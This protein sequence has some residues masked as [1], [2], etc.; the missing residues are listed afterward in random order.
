[1]PVWYFKVSLLH[2][3]QLLANIAGQLFYDY[4]IFPYCAQPNTTVRTANIVVVFQTS[5]L[6]A[7]IFNWQPI[8]Y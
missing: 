4:I 5:V 6:N 2:M 7:A 1:M 8:V 3:Q